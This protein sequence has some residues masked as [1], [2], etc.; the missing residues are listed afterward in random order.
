MS[1]SRVRRA[2]EER[3]EEGRG[4]VIVLLLL[5]YRFILEEC[6]IWAAGWWMREGGTDSE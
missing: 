1:T 3:C 6:K 5:V 4:R 2:E